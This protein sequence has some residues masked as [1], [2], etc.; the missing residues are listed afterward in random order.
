MLV[1]SA[2]SGQLGNRLLLFAN[3]MAF[4]LE[5]N[6]RVLN[7]SFAEY[8]EFFQGTAKDLFCCYPSPALTI[9]GNKSWR[10][11]YY[12]INRY[13][14]EKFFFKTIEITREKPFNWS[15]REIIAQEVKKNGITFMKGWLFR[16][17]WF[18][19]DTPILRKHAPAIREYFKPLE[20]H[21]NNVLKL[22]SGCRRNVD[23][24][25]G[26]HIRHGDYDQHQKGRYFYPTEAYI[27]MM[28]AVK[29]L[30]HNKRVKFLICSN[31]EQDSKLFKEFDYCFGNNHL[32]EDMYALAE[33]D[34]IM[35]PPSSYTRWAS[36]Y[37]EKPL[38]AI[39]NINKE[40]TLKDFVHYY[41][42]KGVFHYDEDWSKSFWEWA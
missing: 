17:G 33:C 3:Y 16:D 12:E 15:E 10:N 34:Y 23:I 38:Y 27:K 42:W 21:R 36:F 7:P 11:K 13:L 29:Q 4:A 6:L 40:P 26:V 31:A 41:E 28:R 1:I 20:K 18:V 8:A 5:N 39:V 35:G 30:F 25:I 24:L 37:G 14:V 22:M 19:S 9:K 2:K 32:V